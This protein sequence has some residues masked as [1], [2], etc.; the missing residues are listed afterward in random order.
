M[1]ARDLVADR[2]FEGLD[3]IDQNEVVVD[4]ILVC[5]VVRG[6]DLGT[7]RSTLIIGAEQHTD[8]FTLTGL[9]SSAT[10]A[11]LRPDAD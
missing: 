5:R 8:P 11:Q 3:D 10:A 7:G 9:L 4:V 1:D 2:T 6:E